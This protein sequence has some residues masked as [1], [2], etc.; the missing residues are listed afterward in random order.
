MRFSRK[1]NIT[2]HNCLLLLGFVFQLVRHKQA[3]AKLAK[4]WKG[5]FRLVWSNTKCGGLDYT[6]T[7][8]CQHTAYNSISQAL[9][10]YQALACQRLAIA[11]SIQNYSSNHDHDS[12]SADISTDW[13]VLLIK[14]RTTHISLYVC[15]FS[16]TFRWQFAIDNVLSFLEINVSERQNYS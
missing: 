1:K 10:S 16:S 5:V 8:G 9:N 7:V 4:I 12:S 2:F 15:A 3:F 6:H 11:F 14:S 13:S